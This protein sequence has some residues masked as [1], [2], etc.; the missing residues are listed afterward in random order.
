M[1]RTRPLGPIGWYNV[2]PHR[3]ESAKPN[4][5]SMFVIVKSIVEF[6]GDREFV[7]TAAKL[8]VEEGKNIKMLQKFPSSLPIIAMKTVGTPS[9]DSKIARV[10]FL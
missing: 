2:I 7:Q 4:K 1:K 10:N 5:A 8:A 6:V 3:H 9:V